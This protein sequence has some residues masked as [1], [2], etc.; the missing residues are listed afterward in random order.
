MKQPPRPPAPKT[1]FCRL[2]KMLYGPKAGSVAATDRTI[3]SIAEHVEPLKTIE[4][5]K[6]V[7]SSF[8]AIRSWSKICN[9]LIF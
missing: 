8:M 3:L 5:A 9:E 1:Q 2:R 6:N 4:F 7:L